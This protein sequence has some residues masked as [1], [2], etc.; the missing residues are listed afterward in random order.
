MSLFG[1]IAAFADTQSGNQNPDLRLIVTVA[2]SGSNPQMATV[3]DVVTTTW[4][5]QNTT[6]R[7]LRVKIVYVIAPPRQAVRNV[8][9]K[10][11]IPAHAAYTN[12]ESTVIVNY[13]CPGTFYASFK[14]TDDLG[15][16]FKS[17]SSARAT[18]TDYN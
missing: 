13:M 4:T 2:S 9:R 1:T 7:A 6:S 16:G 10:L 15:P 5:V 17:F 3:G 18:V 8:T 14:T 12:S 11:T